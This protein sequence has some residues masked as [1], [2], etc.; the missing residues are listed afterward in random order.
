ML[1]LQALPQPLELHD[2]A[3]AVRTSFGPPKHTLLGYGSGVVFSDEFLGVRVW[4]RICKIAAVMPLYECAECARLWAA[5]TKADATRIRAEAELT[6]A[7]FSGDRVSIQSARIAER[8]ALAEWE[9]ADLFVRQHRR[10][11]VMAAGTAKQ[12]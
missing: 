12:L 6:K 11:H 1:D 2:P 7:N 8:I 3:E 10:S 4:K 9:T 5:Y